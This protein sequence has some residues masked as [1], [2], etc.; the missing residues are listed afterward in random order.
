MTIDYMPIY[1]QAPCKH[2]PYKIIVTESFYSRFTQ[3]EVETERER[4]EREINYPKPHTLVVT[5]S[6]C[7]PNPACLQT[8][9]SL[10]DAWQSL[11]SKA[12]M[13]DL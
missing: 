8:L 2:F 10:H 3:E 11:F 4:E 13:D 6:R 12:G 7:E 5:E 1:V 9:Y